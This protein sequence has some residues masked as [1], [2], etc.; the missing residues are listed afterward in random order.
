MLETDL[1]RATVIYLYLLHE[2]IATLRPKLEYVCVHN[3]SYASSHLASSASSRP[4]LSHNTIRECLAD[5]KRPGV[6]IVCNTWGLP[7]RT[8]TAVKD[9]GAYNNVRL[10]LYMGKG[11]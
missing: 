11:R 2:G 4:P 6:R 7:G 1:G 10:L 3:L 9:V 5:P 8:P